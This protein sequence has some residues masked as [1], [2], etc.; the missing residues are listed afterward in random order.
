MRTPGPEPELSIVVPA[1]DEAASL[2]RLVEEVEAGVLG[3]GIRAELIVVDDGSA[4][5]TA[6]VLARLAERRPWLRVLRH[7]RRLGQ[8][9]ALR[10]GVAAARGAAV[11]TLDADGQN[12]PADLP[13]M[14]ARLHHRGG[15][16]D[17]V[18][19]VR[20]DRRDGVSKRAASA[21]GR[22]ARR[23]A[24]GDRVRDAG[25]STRVVRAEVAAAWPLGRPGMHRF[26]P[27]LSAAAGFRVVEVPVNHRARA[28]G[29][30]HYGN[31][32]RGA[33]GLRDLIAVRGILRRARPAGGPG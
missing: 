13:E 12:D 5:A 32:G 11:A 6:E 22:L 33:R 25:C 18:Q 8:T 23:V 19:G 21:V 4:D 30:S 31:L 9:A 29:R 26:L 16:A 20:V 1:H 27:A 7:G 10:T 24:L 14:L 3:R 15:D 28:A 2:A 17:F